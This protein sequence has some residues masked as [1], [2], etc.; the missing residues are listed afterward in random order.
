MKVGMATCG[1]ASGARETMKYFMDELELQAIDAIVTKPAAW[2]I[3]TP[4]PLLKLF[5][6]EKNRLFSAMW[7]IRKAVKSLMFTSNAETY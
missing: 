2:D 6:P 5:C 4:N 3:A 1:I 7:T